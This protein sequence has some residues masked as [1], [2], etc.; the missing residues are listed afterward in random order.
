MF[1]SALLILSGNM[2]SSALLFARNLALA[3]LIPV[4]DYGIAATFALVMTGVE[5][6]S[7]LGLQQ[8]IVQARDGDDPH[9]QNALAGF[10]LFRGLLSAVALFFLAGPIADFL[11]VPQVA[12]AYQVLAVVPLLRA[13]QHFD[14]HRLNRTH[15][16]WPLVLTNT[17]PPL[18]SLIALWPLAVWLG[19]WR[20]ML[21]ALV[22][23]D[24]LTTAMSHLV[25]ER[26]F[27]VA[28]DRALWGRS[29]RFGW[30]IL[31]NALILFLVF[32]GDKLVVGR[33]LGME[34][35]GV[36][37]LAVTLTL[38]PAL[39]LTKS[40]QTIFLPRLS[41]KGETGH[42]ARR[43]VAL[44]L[45]AGLA[46]TCLGV[47]GGVLLAP[48]LMGTGYAA[49]AAFVGPL[50]LVQGFRIA[51][52]AGTIVA[53]SRGRTG[54]AAWSNVPRIASLAVGIALVAGGGSI[55]ALI[56]T[57][58]L[59]EAA[60]MVLSLI[61]VVRDGGLVLPKRR[62]AIWGVGMAAAAVALFALPALIPAAVIAGWLS[63]AA[64][65]GAQR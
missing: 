34:A 16:F 53:L 4:G 14:I 56:W 21:I 26:R 19:D 25:A 37:A 7:A 41:A 12:W 35:L 3:A 57:A 49:L 43:L 47:L 29:L 2:V 64:L 46:V 50:A 31:V 13:L 10:Q 27:G 5:M 11:N 60:G 55:P 58:V 22:F 61:L 54:N 63:R 36:F 24:A 48:L 20:V 1:R 28:V 18:L 17:V 38:T 23:N 9:L 8:Q 52:S 33:L 15:R 51:K 65:T 42:V 62:L 40:L 32:Q 6:A 45:A 30:P 44:A 39:V 59:G